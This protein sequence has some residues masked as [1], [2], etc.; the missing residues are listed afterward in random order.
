MIVYQLIPMNVLVIL[1]VQEIVQVMQ[2]HVLQIVQEVIVIPK[3]LVR[4]II[5]V[6]KMERIVIS[7][8]IHVHAILKIQETLLVSAILRLVLL[9][10][11]NAEMI[12]Q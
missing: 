8:N 2:D 10:I 4:V 1:Y 12:A 11:M 6:E 7:I 5:I 9:I 3:E